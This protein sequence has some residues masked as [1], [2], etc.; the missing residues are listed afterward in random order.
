VSHIIKNRAS[1]LH[2]DVAMAVSVFPQQSSLFEPKFLR[3]LRV[4]NSSPCADKD[5]KFAHCCLERAIT[6][7][8]IKIVKRRKGFEKEFGL[9]CLESG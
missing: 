4:H 5:E 3:D 9:Q 6:I 1:T 2:C 7:M 8:N